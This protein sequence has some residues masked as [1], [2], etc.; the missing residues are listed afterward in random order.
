MMV[1]LKR[2]VFL[3]VFQLVAFANCAIQAQTAGMELAYLQTDRTVY[4]AGESVF[5]KFYLIDSSIKKFSESSKV[6]YVILRA[7]NLNAS[8]KIRVKIDSGMANGSIVLPDTLTSG[9]YQIVAFTSSMKNFGD[10]NFFHKDIVIANRYDKELNLKLV[11]NDSK[12]SA[13]TKLRSIEPKLSTDKTVYGIREKVK[14]SLNNFNSNGNMAVSVFEDPKILSTNNSIVETISETL[15][16]PVKRKLLTGFSVE[17]KGK[18][19]R[20]IVIDQTTKKS[21]S[22]ATVLVSCIDSVPNLQYAITNANGM[23]QLLLDNYYNGKELF[24]TIKDMPENQ[25][26]KIEIEDEFAQSEKWSPSLIS[27]NVHK[28]EFFF[29]SQDMV[30]IN[31]SYLLNNK[32]TEE[33]LSEGASV[34][35]QLY[36]CPVRTVYPSEFVPLDSFPEIAVELLPLVSINKYNG[37]YRAQIMNPT[38]SLVYNYNKEPAIFLD[39]VFVDDI[40]NIISL[41]SEQIKKIDVVYTERIFGDLVFQGVISIISNSNEISR[42]TPAIQSIRL[43]NDTINTGK[44]FEI[45]NPDSIQNKNFPFFKQLLY[46][47]PDIVINDTGT[48]DFEFYTSDNP[49]NFIIRVEGISN[50]GTPYNASTGIHVNNQINTPEK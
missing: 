19:L 46:W 16:A 3:L 44:R 4:V 27:Q 30:Y 2:L 45:F 40:N 6:G 9:A 29:K 41:G 31:K 32:S 24:L 42:T 28:K 47:N 21:V 20:G 22:G 26:W 50:D 15:K 13:I 34:C 33:T 7:A 25:R 11:S 17:N 8:L 43:K 48:T 36:H 35:P 10:E 39:G 38:T 1:L 23:F 49:A 18:I 37:K 5:Y 12:D 14:V